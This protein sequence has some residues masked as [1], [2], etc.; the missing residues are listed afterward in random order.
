MR[1]DV[2]QRRLLSSALF[3]ELPYGRQSQRQALSR[4][5][6]IFPRLVDFAA[7]D[8]ERIPRLPGLIQCVMKL[9]GLGV[10]EKADQQSMWLDWVLTYLP[11]RAAKLGQ[12]Y[13]SLPW[14]LPSGSMAHVLAAGDLSCFQAV[15]AAAMEHDLE[16]EWG[17]L[18]QGLGTLARAPHLRTVVARMF[19]GQPHRCVKLIEQLGL[20]PRLGK[21]AA[22]ALTSLEPLS[23]V[24]RIE[25]TEAQGPSDEWQQL[26]AM[27]PELLPDV[28]A[29]LSAQRVLGGEDRLPPALWRLLEQ[30]A[31]WTG[32][33]RYLEGLR[34]SH[35]ER[36][37]LASREAN[38]R[39]RLA[40]REGVLRSM[41]EELVE[42]FPQMAVEAEL[43]AIERRVI[44]CYHRYLENM[45][46][47]MPLEV[48]LNEDMLNAA[49]LMTDIKSNRKLLLRLL[50]AYLGGERRWPE[51][52]PT[53]VD[54]LE[55]LRAKGV[56]TSTWLGSHA[57]LYSCNGAAGGRV[58]IRLER[59]PLSILQMGNYFDTCLSFG[60]INSFSAVANACELNKRVIYARD[61]K[62]TVVGRKLL[63]ISEEGKLVG[64]HTYCAL[65]DEGGGKVLRALF[66]R[67][68]SEF[69]RRCGL[70]LADEGTVPRLFAQRWYDD[71]A[72]PWA[73]EEP[74][75]GHA[76]KCAQLQ[77][78]S[79]S[80]SHT[81]A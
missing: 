1:L 54:Y 57:R 39:A 60:G 46:G 81:T 6:P 27:V 16:F 61:G 13:E 24:G 29:Y 63:G 34:K 26:L 37:D 28:R 3:Y 71:G 5:L 25:P 4:L 33:L 7:E 67:C 75:E 36:T 77:R 31:R 19:P 49:L 23:D 20:L 58:H 50:R 9:S 68:A 62:G 73:S 52:H 45:T 18:E 55:K 56:D 14:L 76:K 21:E 32:E 78:G 38:L 41:R 44:D 11:Q 43:K 51:Q 70:E 64:F 42:T 79:R 65:E 10:E 80:G 74:A 15:F 40:D 17:R 66:K 59:D 8:P 72:E 69:A 47:M 30:P 48:E 12:G 35:P 2:E 22:A 53:N